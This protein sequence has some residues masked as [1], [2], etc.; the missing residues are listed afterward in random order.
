[1]TANSTEKR[2]RRK[3]GDRPAK[4]RPGF[5]L[6]AHPS[7]H[8][9]KKIR[10]RIHYF[11]R[12]CRRRNGKLERVEGDGWR[13]AY[14][15]Y[16]EQEDDLHAGRTPRR[17]KAGELTLRE[18]CNA[19]LTAKK[20][21]LDAKEIG[22]RMFGEYKSITDL[23]IH[24]FGKTRLVDDLISED[25]EH[26]RAVMAKRW[27]PTRLVNTITRVKSVFKYGYESGLTDKP[28]R[29]GPQFKK[30]SAAVLRRHRAS[31]GKRMLTAAECRKLLEAAPSPIKAMIYLGLNCGFGNHDCATLPLSAVDLD[32]A[33]I[34]YPRPKSGVE[35]RCPLWPETVEAL[36]T[37]IAA[38]PKP[39]MDEAAGLVFITSRGRHWLSGGIANPI[40][41]AIRTLM[42]DAGVHRAG[43]GPYTLRHV[44][45]TVADGA[46]DTPAIDLVM[47][48]TDPSMAAHYRE[49]IEDDRLRA[50]VEHV[51]KWLFDAKGDK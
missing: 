48:H 6:Y 47:G 25:F 4:P 9:A 42:K 26:L 33:M 27:G 31:N 50:V 5:P 20:R 44:F 17:A 11:G 39:K 49:H 18:L 2:R 3:A 37:A 38:R 21:Q 45:R 8:W 1:M 23:L 35:R 34:D 30:P 19:F 22:V 10:G 51:R 28:T 12:W 24:Q 46:K 16:K 15:A 14:K 7:G 40:S 43:I 29:F 13:Q 32:S 36:R 41:Q